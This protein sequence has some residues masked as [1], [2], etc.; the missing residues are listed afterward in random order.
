MQRIHALLAVLLLTAL[1]VGCAPTMAKKG[2]KA[3]PLP[4]GT[5]SAVEVTALFSDRTVESILDSNGRISLTYYNPNGELSQLQDGEKR[6]GIW[7]V[8]KDGR[9]CLA[10]AGSG[11]K[12]RIIVKEGDVYRKYIVKKSGTH[13]RII[14][15][16][17]F[18]DG[19]L[20]K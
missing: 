7:R 18:S 10:F 13:E 17:S 19:N 9:I 4:P 1:V 6:N 15:Y 16:R 8:R 14:T 20:V 3:T 12:C 5:L 2:K 11:E